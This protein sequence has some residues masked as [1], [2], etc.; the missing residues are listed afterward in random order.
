LVYPGQSRIEIRPRRKGKGG[1]RREMGGRKCRDNKNQL[2]R[3][4]VRSVN[5]VEAKG[6]QRRDDYVWGIIK[7]TRAARSY[8]RLKEVAGGEEK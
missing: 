5:A 7:I 8:R 2:N 1:R 3:G 6:K 4:P